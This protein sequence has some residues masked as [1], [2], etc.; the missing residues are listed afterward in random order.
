MSTTQHDANGITVSTYAG[1]K[2]GVK[3]RRRVQLDIGDKYVQMSM[4]QWSA[5]CA[6]TDLLGPACQGYNIGREDGD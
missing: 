6:I 2:D 5:L 3:P 4:H 1:P